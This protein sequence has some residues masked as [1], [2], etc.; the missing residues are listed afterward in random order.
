M[1]FSLHSQIVKLGSLVS[2]TEWTNISE[3]LKSHGESQK[4][5]RAD[6]IVQIH[7]NFPN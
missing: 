5:T 2:H 1:F 7:N 3:K 4:E 6:A